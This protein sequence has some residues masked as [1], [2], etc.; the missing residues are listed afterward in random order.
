MAPMSWGPEKLTWEDFR[1]GPGSDKNKHAA[2]TF[3]GIEYSWS[4]TASKNVFKLDFV[5]EANFFPERSWVDPDKKTPRLLAHEQLHFDISELHARKLLKALEAYV[6]MRNIRADLQHIYTNI[7]SKRKKM[8]D[9]YDKETDHGLDEAAQAKWN[10]EIK[11]ALLKLKAYR[12][13]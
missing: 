2:S 5:V 9:R 11:E 8:Q 7:Q 1:A 10:R 4:Y 3:S 13:K 12:R 6:P